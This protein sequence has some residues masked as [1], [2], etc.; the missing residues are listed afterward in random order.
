MSGG[1]RMYFISYAS[2]KDL[3]NYGEGLLGLRFINS[4]V[5]KLTKNPVRSGCY[6]G[7]LFSVDGKM[8]TL[9]CAR[10]KHIKR[11]EK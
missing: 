2:K 9:A 1:M 5:A 10:F 4:E 11:D 7:T 6:Q 8:V 3:D